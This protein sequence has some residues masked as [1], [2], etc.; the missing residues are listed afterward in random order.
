MLKGIDQAHDT[1]LTDRPNIPR[2]FKL[3]T[4]EGSGPDRGVLDKLEK[5]KKEESLRISSGI[6]V[7]NLLSEWSLL[8]YSASF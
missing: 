2:L 7:L 6:L 8:I 5:N 3:S 1:M 4:F